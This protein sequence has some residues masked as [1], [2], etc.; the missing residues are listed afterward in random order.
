[1]IKLFPSKFEKIQIHSGDIYAGFR[2][3]GNCPKTRIAVSLTALS[4]ALLDREESRGLFQGNRLDDKHTIAD[5]E[6]NAAGQKKTVQHKMVSFFFFFW[7]DTREFRAQPHMRYEHGHRFR[8]VIIAQTNF[9]LWKIF[10]S[11]PLSSVHFV[12]VKTIT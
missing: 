9:T 12:T 2:A 1:M 3:F 5:A 6:Q 7:H 8:E 4:S 11:E 10:Y